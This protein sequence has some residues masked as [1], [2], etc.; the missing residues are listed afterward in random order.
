MEYLQL[1]WLLRNQIITFIQCATISFFEVEAF[2]TDILT[3]N[4]NTEV[5]K[6]ES[7][8]GAAEKFE[9]MTS[10]LDIHEKGKEYSDAKE[11]PAIYHRRTNKTEVESVQL[12]Y[13]Y[14]AY[15]DKCCGDSSNLL[16]MFP[17]TFV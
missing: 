10:I 3:S 14:I 9:T 2:L 11:L 17:S 15:M 7:V 12:G 6:E 8:D 4:I 16:Y 5:L 1:F 13:I